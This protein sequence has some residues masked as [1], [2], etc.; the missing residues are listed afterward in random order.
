MPKAKP[1]IQWG[2]ALFLLFYV[3]HA[4]DTAAS[5]IQDTFELISK[6]FHSIGNVISFKSN[7]N[8]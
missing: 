2:V 4:P 5:F 7:I 3:V 6:F 1:A 8:S